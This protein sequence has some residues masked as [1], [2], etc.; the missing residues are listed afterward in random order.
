M[1]PLSTSSNINS[2]WLMKLSTAISTREPFRC[3]VRLRYRNLEFFHYSS[4]DSQLISRISSSQRLTKKSGLNQVGASFVMYGIVTTAFPSLDWFARG[5]AYWDRGLLYWKLRW[6]NGR[7]EIDPLLHHSSSYVSNR[8]R[9]YR[10]SG[11]LVM[12]VLPRRLTG[13][14]CILYAVLGSSVRVSVLQSCCIINPYYSLGAIQNLL[15][16]C[17]YSL[18]DYGS[19]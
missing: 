9:E 16:K 3:I 12:R 13:W 17:V 11:D 10:I 15:I 1:A 5:A 14:L 6:R 4:A 8:S 18:A 2:L 7:L 19:K